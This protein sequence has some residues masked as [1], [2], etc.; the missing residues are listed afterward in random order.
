[1]NS[2]RETKS[3][4]FVFILNSFLYLALNSMGIEKKKTIQKIRLTC[5]VSGQMNVLS[6]TLLEVM[7]IYVEYINTWFIFYIWIFTMYF[8]FSPK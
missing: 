1:M 7:I 8:L 6:K 5:S 4:N 2:K 3:W